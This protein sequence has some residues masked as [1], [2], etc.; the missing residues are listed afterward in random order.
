M[1]SRK[2]IVCPLDQRR[3]ATR[4]ALA[5][6]RAAAHSSGPRVQVRRRPLVMSNVARSGTLPGVTSRGKDLLQSFTVGEKLSVGAVVMNKVISPLSMDPSRFSS[7]S[8]LWSRWKPMSL[9]VTVSGAGASTT[10]GSV[11]LGWDPDGRWQAT[12]SSGDYTRVAALVP[13]VTLRLHETKTFVIPPEVTRKW[14]FTVGS[15]EDSAHGALIGVVASPC[16]GFTG[17]VGVNVILDWVV[18]FEGADTPSRGGSVDSDTVKP[19]SGWSNLFTTS[20]G[21][22][23]SGRLT[24]K[25]HSGGAMCP[26]SAARQDHVYTPASG[27][28]VPYIDETGKTQ[29]VAAF[30]VI[31]GFA[32][33]GFAC[34]ASE[35]NAVSYVKTGDV[36]KV[37]AYKAAG[38]YATPAVPIFI[39][40]PA[41]PGI[42]GLR[43]DPLAC[44][45]AHLRSEIGSLRELVASQLAQ[46]NELPPD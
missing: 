28:K 46:G 10:F 16:G 8:A 25:M 17:S 20:D 24:L 14:Y 4:A 11:C 36:D 27:T 35:A 26:F 7:E 31:Q 2:T 34:F 1:S 43:D 19:D 15:L 29:H 42:A 30:A 12:M 9:R 44:E 5:Q 45:V 3:F 41:A 18:Q 39:G 21:D 33:P 32:T 40:K 38:D 23:D 13:S 37:L 22:W 6:H